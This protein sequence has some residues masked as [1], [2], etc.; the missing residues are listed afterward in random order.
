VLELSLDG[1]FDVYTGKEW[2]TSDVRAF[3][4]GPWIKS[5]RAVIKECEQQYTLYWERI[6]QE[7]RHQETE[8]LKSRFGITIAQN[9]TFVARLVSQVRRFIIRI[10]GGFR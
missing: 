2:K 10:A 1:Y 9:P 3:I 6:E 7:R 4:E 5:F 8:D